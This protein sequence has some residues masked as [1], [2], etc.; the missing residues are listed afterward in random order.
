LASVY[1]GVKQGYLGADGF[2][3]KVAFDAKFDVFDNF[4]I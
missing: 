4:W 3:K 2:I 1:G